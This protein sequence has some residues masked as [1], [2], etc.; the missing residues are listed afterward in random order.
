MSSP[1]VGALLR[2]IFFWLR[3]LVTRRRARR[4]NASEDCVACGSADTARLPSDDGIG[5]RACNTCGYVG[6]GDGGGE[7]SPA[8]LAG[9]HADDGGPFGWGN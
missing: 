1:L 9:L 2:D 6:R 7:L 8:D 4:L 5:Q 3:G